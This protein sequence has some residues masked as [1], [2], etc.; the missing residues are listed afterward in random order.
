MRSITVYSHPAATYLCMR[1]SE[2]RLYTHQLASILLTAA[3]DWP[4]PTGQVLLDLTISTSHVE[5]LAYIHVFDITIT[6]PRK[7]SHLSLLA[8][9]VAERD[10]AADAA[11]VHE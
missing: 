7:L 4:R 1:G 6:L 11:N 3:Q 9:V 5:S 8:T 10:K 2:L